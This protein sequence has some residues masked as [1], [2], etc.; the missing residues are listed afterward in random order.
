MPNI[1]SQIAGG[2]ATADLRRSEAL[3]R[4]AHNPNL[5]LNCHKPIEVQPKHTVAETRRKKFCSKTCAS[6]FNNR[7]MIYEEGDT[8]I[9]VYVPLRTKGEVYKISGSWQSARNTIRRQARLAYEASN[10]PKSC[11]ICGYKNH[12]EV[13]HIKAV[14]D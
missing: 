6:T 2:R 9:P 1:N 8:E 11:I 5:C 13:C 7:N 3:D 14:S 12:Y 10:K 4:Y